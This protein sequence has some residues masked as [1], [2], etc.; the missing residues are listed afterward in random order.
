MSTNKLLQNHP[1][2]LEYPTKP[3]TLLKHQSLVFR[4]C[5]V[6]LFIVLICL[7][8][9]T[10]F[11]L[12]IFFFNSDP[13]PEKGYT[14]VFGMVASTL[15]ALALFGYMAYKGLNRPRVEQ[16]LYYKIAGIEPLSERQRQAL[17]LDIVPCYQYGYWVETLES[18]AL[19]SRV[20]DR[21]DQFKILQLVEA[22][23]FSEPLLEWWGIKNAED[24]H[25]MISQLWNGMHTR[26]FAL[27]VNGREGKALAGQLAGLIGMPETYVLNCTKPGKDNRPPSLVWGFDLWRAINITRWAFGAG[28]ISEQQAWKDLLYSADMVHEIFA[29]FNQYWLSYRLGN[30]Y[31]SRDPETTRQRLD[32]WVNY[33][34]YCDWP[35]AKLDW[36][37]RPDIEL[38]HNIRSGFGRVST[39]GSESNLD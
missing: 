21:Q 4:I 24:Y 26:D 13:I 22:S 15:I 25:Q 33:E 6:L 14:L 32:V 7:A 31:W 23:Y 18:N 39:A 36:P 16:R 34:S 3:M 30:A 10:S 5:F 20:A 29:S 27:N 11:T 38:S 17:R 2:Y 1:G 9:F 12:A 19:K 8:A 35:I 37:A 28:Y